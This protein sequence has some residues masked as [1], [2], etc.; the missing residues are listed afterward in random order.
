M[1]I[2]DRVLF[3]SQVINHILELEN[4]KVVHSVED[5]RR[6]RLDGELTTVWLNPGEDLKTV[7]PSTLDF[8][9]YADQV[10]NAW[11]NKAKVELGYQ[12]Q[13]RSAYGKPIVIEAAFGPNMEPIGKK[14]YGRTISDLFMRLEEIGVA[15]SQVKWIIV[16]AGFDIRAERNEKRRDGIPTRYFDRF[17]ASGGDLAP[18]HQKIFE[19]QGTKISR[20]FNDHDDIERFRADVIAAFKEMR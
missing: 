10:M 1:F 20:V 12:I 17:A 5:D 19:E 11:R 9:V 6:H 15:P 3:A 16:E 8:D 14:P 7:D 2:T 18:D 13:E 4:S